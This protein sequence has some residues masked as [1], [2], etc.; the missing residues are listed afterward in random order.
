M[1]IVLQGRLRSTRLPAKGFFTFFEQ[2]LWE[3]LC[4]IA[5]S[6][7]GVEEVVFATGSNYENELIRPHVVKKGVRWFVG[8]EDNVIERF[9]RSIESYRGKYL[10]RI[11][12]DNYL[13]QPDLLENLY[14][15]TAE[16]NADYGY[17]EPLSHF[18]GEILRCETLRNTYAGNYSKEAR[19]HVTYDI[20]NSLATKTVV[21]P[22]N[23]MG[24]DHTKSVTLDTIDDLITMKKLE[25]L[26]Y[27]LKEIRCLQTIV[28]LQRND[29]I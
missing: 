24:V 18:A 29:I 27:N 21:L 22:S 1:I 8:S 25:S 2:L 3:R 16:Q 9:V 15:L 23:F 7:K 14:N 12:C 28:R 11:T 5:L 17:I 26:E 10:I 20:R 6:V 13:V 4:D 19:E